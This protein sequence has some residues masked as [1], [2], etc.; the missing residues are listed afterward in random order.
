MGERGGRRPF[1]EKKRLRRS[2]TPDQEAWALATELAA[3]DKS[4]VSQLFDQL[5]NGEASRRDRVD[6]RSRQ[7]ADTENDGSREPNATQ[8]VEKQ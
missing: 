2:I 8:I 7:R 1:G 4:S 3:E 5:V 6:K